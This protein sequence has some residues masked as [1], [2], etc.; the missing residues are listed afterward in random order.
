MRRLD[1]WFVLLGLIVAT[2]CLGF[3]SARHSWTWDW[4]RGARASLAPESVAVLGKLP[5][6]VE[7]VGYL[8]PAGP[9]R[10]QIAGVMERYTRAKPDLVLSFVDPDLDP[11]ASR[12]LGIAGDGA[13][14]IRYHGRE[15]RVESPINERNLSNALERLARGGQRIVA[16]VTGDGERQADGRANADLGTFMRQVERRG[17]RAVP[18]NFSQTRGVPEH[19]DLVVLASPVAALPAQSVTALVDYV[20]DGGNLLW[21]TEPANDDLGTGALADVLGVRV[22]PGVL[23]DGQ[24]STLNV[25]DPR[26]VV[27]GDYP[28]H[29]ITRA[30]RETTLFPQVAALAQVS[31]HDWAVVPFLRSGERSWTA[32]GGIDNDKPSTVAFHPEAG[33]L[34]GPLDFAFALNR[35]SPSPAKSEQRAVVIGDG[36]FLSNTYVGNGGNRALG[37]RILD[38][39]LGDDVLV[40]LPARGAPDR[41]ISLSQDGLNAVTFG[42]LV[43]LPLVLLALGVGI[44]WRRRRR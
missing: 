9:L 33:E 8:S 27:V 4:T 24:G 5:G 13:L 34:K 29:A 14:L 1:R 25:N 7:V 12:Q 42:F 39:L 21:L 10:E 15:E 38:W 6:R 26:L 17:I 22:L 11:A 23:V 30:F 28:F 3:L 16:F 2:G 44:A 37:E 35:L 36:D 20:R 19:T 18:L 40:D 41:V 32:F 43:F 31:D